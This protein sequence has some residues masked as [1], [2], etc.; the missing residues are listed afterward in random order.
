MSKGRGKEFPVTSME[1]VEDAGLS[2]ELGWVRVIDGDGA[3]KA[4][5]SYEEQLRR[6]R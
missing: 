2:S 3:A 1:K 5:S 6:R 4:S